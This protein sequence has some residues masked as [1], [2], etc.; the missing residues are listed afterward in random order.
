MRLQKGHLQKI[1]SAFEI[2]RS[3]DRELKLPEGVT[4]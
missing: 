4:I 2:E 1:P 3:E